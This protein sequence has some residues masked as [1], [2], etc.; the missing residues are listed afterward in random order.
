MKNLG[1]TAVLTDSMQLLSKRD[2]RRMLLISA[3]QILLGL[4]DLLGVALLGLVGTLTISGIQSASPSTQISNY[5]NQLHLQ[6][7]SFQ[8]QVAI[9]S[10]T[11]ALVLFTR[12]IFSIYI[13]RRTLHFFARRAAQMSSSLMSSLLAQD[14]T[15][16]SRKTSQETIYSLTVGTN[17][18]FMGV[19]ATSITLIGDIAL[20]AILGIGLVI[21]D[22]AVATSSLLLFGSLILIMH[23][24]LSVK[25]RQLGLKD[26]ELSVKSNLKIDEAIQSYRELYVHD[27]LKTYAVTFSVVREKYA[28]VQAEMIFLP[29]ISK[30]VIESGLILGAF[31]ISGIQFA[32]HDASHAFATLSVFLAAGSRLAPAVLRIQQSTLQ[33][34]N[35]S[36]VAS[37]A[38]RFIQELLHDSKDESKDILHQTTPDAFSPDISMFGVNYT[39]PG[40]E[41]AAVQSLNLQIKSGSRIGIVGQSGSGKSTLVDLLLGVITPTNGEILISGLN[42]ASAVQKYPG[43][44]SYVPQEV[45]ITQD[46]LKNNVAL[47][48]EPSKVSN[49]R[50]REVLDQ[51]GLLEQFKELNIDLDTEIGGNARLLSGGQKQRLGLARALYTSPKLLVLDE[52]SSALDAATEA[53]LNQELNDLGHEIT[54]IQIAHRL[55]SI[56]NS[57][58]IYYIESGQIKESGT[59]TELRSLLPEFDAQASIMGL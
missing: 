4:L 44:I 55:S 45:F 53:D 41:S 22:L 58:C 1:F 49:S 25:S 13:T 57:D 56:K 23:F 17:A 12:T 29:N 8:G 15:Y 32:I 52:F 31:I 10:G 2:K 18:L 40:S 26:A 30:Y 36:G 51:C 47:G 39:Y 27:N 14:L 16:V 48:I 3:L 35:N 19:I 42:P 11:A 7:F 50:V 46:S 43:L 24:T 37:G 21:I 20:V 38:I 5:L 34:R 54:I 6:S 33:I 9:L 28:N 59:F